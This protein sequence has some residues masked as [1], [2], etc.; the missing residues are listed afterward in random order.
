MRGALHQ[1]KMNCSE[2][3]IGAKFEMNSSMK[4]DYDYNSYASFAQ[5]RKFLANMVL[6]CA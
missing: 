5:K 6:A 4:M 3:E 1:I 2:A